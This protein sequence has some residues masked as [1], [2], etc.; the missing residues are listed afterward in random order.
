MIPAIYLA[1]VRLLSRVTSQMG[2]QLMLSP[3]IRSIVHLINRNHSFIERYIST[4]PEWTL[5]RASCPKA[6]VATVE[7][8]VVIA[9]MLSEVLKSIIINYRI[10]VLYRTF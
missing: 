3:A 6:L 9:D 4:V 2:H 5:P 8:D 1:H 7:L 10:T